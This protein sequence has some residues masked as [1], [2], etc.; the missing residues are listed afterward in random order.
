M[1]T[2]SV[3]SVKL[4]QIPVLYIMI[5]TRLPSEEN[6]VT[7]LTIVR[8]VIIKTITLFFNKSFMRRA[9]LSSLRRQMSN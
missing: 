1:I 6:T 3:K 7:Y 2:T 4:L 9:E 5:D 8:T